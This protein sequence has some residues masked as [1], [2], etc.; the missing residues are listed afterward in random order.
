MTSRVP[1]SQVF[2]R[3]NAAAEAQARQVT[4]ALRIDGAQ[5]AQL[6]QQVQLLA[7]VVEA[8]PV[9]STT[10][11]RA[12]GFALSGSYVTKVQATIAVPGSK[13]LAQ[14]L[15]VGTAAVLDETSG[16]L[17]VAYGQIQ[18]DGDTGAEFPA[19][20]DA[21]VSTVNNI[22]TA[23]HARSWTV[24]AGGSFTVT[25]QLKGLNPTAFPGDV[26]NFAQIAVFASFTGGAS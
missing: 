25:M 5:F 20:K 14:V 11:T 23:T 15:V 22:V 3:Q 16:G 24:T 17:T 9:Q 8:L 19:S 26:N 1:P 6:F 10:V 13:D 18:I 21:G 4:D 2:G 7:Q 12:S